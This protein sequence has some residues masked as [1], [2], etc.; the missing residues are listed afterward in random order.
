MEGWK[1]DKEETREKSLKSINLN[2]HLIAKFEDIVEGEKD[3]QEESKYQ[4]NY[5]KS[6]D[7][8]NF[9]LGRS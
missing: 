9:E 7:W 1:G 5:Y 8:R 3:F 2:E 6:L 4:I